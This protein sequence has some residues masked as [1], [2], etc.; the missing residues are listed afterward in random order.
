M[1]RLAG[2]DGVFA[3]KGYSSY[4]FNRDAKSWR[5]T[6]IFKFE[7]KDVQ[8]V[9]LQ[10][11]KRYDEAIEKLK[12][13]RE[14]FKSRKESWGALMQLAVVYHVQEKNAE[15]RKTLEEIIRDA[16][17]DSLLR[18]ARRLEELTYDMGRVERDAAVLDPV[19]DAR[20]MVDH[21]V[22]LARPRDR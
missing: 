18:D 16:A 20:Q 8:K 13:V 22:P 17:I 4:L 6:T 1:T 12:A 11:E 19:V 5:D 21:R 10:N 2:K 14:K 3:V 7:E 9:T 15:A